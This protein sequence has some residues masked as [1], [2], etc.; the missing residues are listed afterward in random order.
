MIPQI[1]F[2]MKKANLVST[3]CWALLL[4]LLLIGCSP[5]RI[6]ERRVRKA[7]EEIEGHWTIASIIYQT[8]QYQ[9]MA[10]ADSL[11]S[12]TVSAANPD[13]WICPAVRRFPNDSSFNFSFLVFDF[14]SSIDSSNL[15]LSMYGGNEAN[16][17]EAELIAWR[18]VFEIVKLNDDSLILHTEGPS[19]KRAGFDQMWVRAARRN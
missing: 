6:V 13:T 5:E 4:G 11:G 1:M 14:Y 17:Q 7:A 16:T 18:G 3:G 2:D 12:I 10:P 9:Q 15:D 19:A 8:D